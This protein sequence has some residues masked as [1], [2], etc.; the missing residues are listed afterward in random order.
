MFGAPYSY[1]NASVK[2]F[3][4]AEQTANMTEQQLP[5]FIPDEPRTEVPDDVVGAL[6][7][8]ETKTCVYSALDFPSHSHICSFSSLDLPR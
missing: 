1:S 3:G 2:G 8:S 4:K 6:E 5:I 7:R